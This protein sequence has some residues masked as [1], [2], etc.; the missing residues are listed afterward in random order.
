M[1]RAVVAL[2]MRTGIP[3]REWMAEDDPRVL[4]TALDLAMRADRDGDAPSN[5]RVVASG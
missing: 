3:V 2:A 1:T 4:D 5:R